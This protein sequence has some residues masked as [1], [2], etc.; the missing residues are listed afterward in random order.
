MSKQLTRQRLSA[1]AAALGAVLTAQSV[2]AEPTLE[3]WKSM[4]GEVVSAQDILAAD[5]TNLGDPAGRVTDLVLSS[6]GESVQYILYEGRFPYSLFGGGDGFVA[7]DGVTFD[8]SWDLT[9]RFEPGTVPSAPERLTLTADQSDHR[10]V[11]RLIDEPLQFAD[12]STRQLEDIL[13]DK[14][15]GAV[16]HYVVETDPDSVFR[17]ERRTVPA[18]EVMIADDG[19]VS[20][21][22][23]LAELQGSQVY[24]RELL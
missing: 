12:G 20:S 6:N 16:T 19:E 5:V 9:V 10:L 1:C 8:Q 15:T 2:G 13:I 21:T 3:D 18:A 23:R 24:D 14:D 17:T 4:R 11:S 22:L 7:F